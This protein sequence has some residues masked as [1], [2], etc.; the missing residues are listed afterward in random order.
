MKIAIRIREKTGEIFVLERGNS[1]N[2]EFGDPK[3]GDEKHHS[4]NVLEFGNIGD[5]L[6]AIGRGMHPRM[7]GRIT[8]QF[9]MISPDKVQILEVPV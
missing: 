2:F 4:K 6:D 9:N 1:G 8:N 3:H 5:A 7:L